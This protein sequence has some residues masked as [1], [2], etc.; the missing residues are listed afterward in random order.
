M[1]VS[2]YTW[3]IASASGGTHLLF[4]GSERIAALGDRVLR[5]APEAHLVDEAS[6]ADVLRDVQH[7]LRV[8]V[9][10]R[11][12]VIGAA[13]EEEFVARLEV[14]VAPGSPLAR[15]A[16]VNLPEERVPTVLLDARRLQDE[17]TA[18]NVHL[19]FYAV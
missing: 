10:N 4:F 9:G 5:Y 13:L 1:G 11:R 6:E 19:S 2:S 3:A 16:T 8:E 7:A 12:K 18:A 17:L 15:V 14:R